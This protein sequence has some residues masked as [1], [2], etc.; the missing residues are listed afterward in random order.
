[1]DVLI[2]ADD[3]TL[4]ANKEDFS[5]SN[6]DSEVNVNL[7]ELN[8]W[9][10]LNKL[11][12]IVNETKFMIFRKRKSINPFKI[13][14]RNISSKLYTNSEVTASEVLSDHEEFSL[15]HVYCIVIS[16][17]DSLTTLY[18]VIRRVRVIVCLCC[19]RNVLIQTEKTLLIKLTSNKIGLTI[20]N[21]NT[22]LEQ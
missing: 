16:E 13:P 4:Y 1:M 20:I 5:S 7:E 19:R 15:Q 10:K 9:F 8:K 11:S 6:L 21:N 14:N 18:Y 12:L 22:K 3:T 17:T 2:Y